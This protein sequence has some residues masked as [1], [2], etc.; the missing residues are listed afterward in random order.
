MQ[1]EH[2][3]YVIYNNG[4]CL[5]LKLDLEWDIGS[6]AT[7]VGCERESAQHAVAAMVEL[8]KDLIDLRDFGLI[9]CVLEDVD[10]LWFEAE[11]PVLEDCWCMTGSPSGP[12]NA[13]AAVVETYDESAMSAL[14]D[15][16]LEYQCEL[17]RNQ[18][19]GWKEMWAFK[20][21]GRVPDS[22][23]PAVGDHL[24]VDDWDNSY[25]NQ[26]V[27]IHRRPDGVWA[28]VPATTPFGL[29]IWRGY[30]YGGYS[31][32]DGCFCTYLHLMV[33]VNWSLWWEEGSPGRAVLDA[34]IERLQGRGWYLAS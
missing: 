34:A 27:P 21:L 1:G 13:D 9:G 11:H 31:E 10:G 32:T 7:A 12:C 28:G 22:V 30:D 17:P 4:S 33:T 23:A 8:C 15:E 20:T 6:G 2:S 26:H 29:Q 14:V 3:G 25:P 18:W 16:L 19:W 5:N 24:I